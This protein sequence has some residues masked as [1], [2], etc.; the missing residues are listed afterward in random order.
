[1][2]V[3]YT[4]TTI[5]AEGKPEWKLRAAAKRAEIHAGIPPEWLLP[6]SVLS[7]PPSNTLTY[8]RTSGI[9]TPLELEITE[10]VSAPVLLARIAQGTYT[11]AAV[12][13]AFSKRAA[14]AQQLTGCC[15]EM[16]FA[17]ALREAEALDE[18][19]ASTGGKTVGPLH[20][21][22]VSLKDLL[23]VQGVDTTEGWVGLIGKPAQEDCGVVKVLRRL[24]AVMYVKT[25][26]SQSIMMSDSYNHVFLQN[27]HSHNR[28]LISGGSS[29]G[30]GAL[31]G[32]LGSIAGFGTDTG[33]SVRIP[34]NMQGCYGL[35]PTVGRVSFADSGK[36]V[37]FI[38]PPV[39][40]PITSSIETMETVLEAYMNQGQ[41]WLAEP[42]VYPIPWRSEL[43]RKPET[44]KKLRIGWYVDD[45]QV[46][47][48]PPITAQVR[49]VV[50]LLRDAGH[51][52]L[53]WSTPEHG[54]LWASWGKA[55]M[56]D[57]GRY[58]RDS[59]ALSGE[60]LIEG[61]IVGT[62]ADLLTQLEA[63]ALSDRRVE[64][65]K[66][67]L[68]RWAESGVDALICPTQTFTGMRTRV[69]VKSD[70]YVGYTC[71]WN[72]LG[73]AALAMPVGV[74]DEE[75]AQ[76]DETWRTHEV[77]N[78]SDKFNHE[79]YEPSLVMGMPV[80]VQVIGGR[81]GEEKTLSVA[82]VIKELLD[83]DN[84]NNGKQ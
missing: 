48:Q 71:V 68:R 18:H 59:C 2:T 57:G 77:R 79:I 9:L 72:W 21:L 28:E 61:M 26:I 35:A 63:E 15:T 12:T 23:D 41:P 54:E 34:S 84:A 44:G 76:P 27:V 40:G 75:N 47:P 83:Q 14:I 13:R 69:W 62:D 42:F 66:A 29:G 45:G 19:Y 22:P 1:M 32:C 16:F 51:E 36:Q 70:Q 58:A 25:N 17:T 3:T 52:V 53:E 6:S 73:F 5:T 31:V 60:P 81:F 11:A 78:K 24:G 43:A 50:G 39:V 64:H 74:I 33:G 10:T 82:K 55:I 8:L 4:T 30:E 80:G 67:Y 7:S 65:Q 20:G 49:R 37:R 56:A 46:L 38:A